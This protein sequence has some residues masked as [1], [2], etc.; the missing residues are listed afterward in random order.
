MEACVGERV[1]VEDAVAVG[2]LVAVGVAVAEGVGV[3][4]VGTSVDETLWGLVWVIT[5]GVW[6]G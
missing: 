4:A 2:E 6:L 1:A 3:V 5:K